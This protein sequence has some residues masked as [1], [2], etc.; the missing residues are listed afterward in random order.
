[1]SNYPTPLPAA[2]NFVLRIFDQ[3]TNQQV[4][5][6]LNFNTATSPSR[7]LEEGVYYA[8]LTDPNRGNCVYRVSDILIDVPV[9]SKPTF[10]DLGPMVYS[11][12]NQPVR[13]F[14]G[15]ATSYTWQA[16]SDK[17]AALPAASSFT[18]LQP[19]NPGITATFPNLPGETKR[20]FV[21]TAVS[22]SGCRK[23]DTAAVTFVNYIA[24]LPI[25]PPRCNSQGPV[26]IAATFSPAISA[27]VAK[28]F[29]YV[30]KDNGATI[31]AN[32]PSI[33]ISSIGTHNL[34]LQF[35]DNRLGNSCIKPAVTTSVVINQ[36][37]TDGLG[38][39]I[40]ATECPGTP[41]T[42]Q[43][44]RAG[45]YPAGS[46][47]KWSSPNIT[48][49]PGSV[50]APAITVTQ[51]AILWL[52]VTS[53]VCTDRYDIKINYLTPPP[54]SLTDA[55]FC[56]KRSKSVTLTAG[57]EGYNYTWTDS[58]TKA[59]VGNDFEL[60]VSKAGTYI[61][62][63][64]DEN[65][66]ETIAKSKV[67]SECEGEILVADAFTPNGDS[68]NDLLKF[69][70][71]D[72]SSF[73]VSIY[74]RWGQLIYNNTN[75]GVGWDGRTS[76]GKDAPSGTYVYVLRYKSSKGDANRIMTQKGSVVLIR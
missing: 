5:A 41:I 70:G 67:I 52:D 57:P 66:C 56:P 16:Y 9:V 71:A 35:T 38:A 47:Y 20:Y 63:I 4:G 26:T 53:G 61:V 28:N 51:P 48:I 23:I 50:S 32:S 34:S 2:Q 40:A 42:V 29:Q 19:G 60:T 45:A 44:T 27:T 11:C 64:V 73:T 33:T 12:V 10:D 54:S 25:I 36:S 43:A 31:N 68:H 72:I 55:K 65:G 46:T 15:N 14:N 13:I 58:A 8:T 18:S 1:V 17:W 37:P 21:V 62:S 24:S 69:Y 22:A 6:A 30:W 3:N 76:G 7:I 39:D 59:V 75:Q 49:P 74:N